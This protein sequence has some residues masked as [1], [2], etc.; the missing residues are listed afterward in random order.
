MLK[1]QTVW[2]LTM[3]SL[4]VVLS[5]YYI[6]IPKDNNDLAFIDQGED[7]QK[8]T[9]E[10]NAN[11]VN[12]SEEDAADIANLNN[13]ELFATIRLEI[14][15]DRSRE[16]ARLESIVSSS[17]SSIEEKDNALKEIDAIGTM[18]TTEKIVEERI[19]SEQGYEDVL[20][21]N[22]KGEK[23]HVHVR[24]DE[25]STEEALKIMQLVRDEF[26]QD[27]PVEV[28]YQSLAAE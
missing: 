22:S 19:I 7:N 15:D 23:V 13:D 6:L 10:E 16:E 4:L 2:L 28:N 20:V 14:Q 24:A 5:V 9:T 11:A 17:T 21:R 26:N 3:L 1:K 27:L 8:S 12:N 18:E 25:L